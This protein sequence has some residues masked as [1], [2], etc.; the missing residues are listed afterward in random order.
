METFITHEIERKKDGSKIV[1]NYFFN[2]TKVNKLV[3][4]QNHFTK[5]QKKEAKFNYNLSLK[6]NIMHKTKQ[7][8]LL[9]HLIKC[10]IPNWNIKLGFI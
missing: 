6:Q 1:R 3:D 7:K 10:D 4:S 5:S 8:E 2:S 9:E